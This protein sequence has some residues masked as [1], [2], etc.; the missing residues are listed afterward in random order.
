MKKLI[1]FLVL[2]NLISLSGFW[3]YWTVNNTWEDIYESQKM[4]P[5][6]PHLAVATVVNTDGLAGSLAF[7]TIRYSLESCVSLTKT[8]NRDFRNILP[9]PN[10]NLVWECREDR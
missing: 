5:N 8:L 6:K 10:N 1:T 3:Y 4:I 7:P 2:T 9:Y